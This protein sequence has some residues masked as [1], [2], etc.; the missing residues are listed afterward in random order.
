M[1][2]WIV[3]FALM[4]L[5]IWL[6]S[7]GSTQTRRAT[8]VRALEMIATVLQSP[9]CLNSHQR[10]Q[11]LQGENGHP[12]SPPV[13]RGLDGRGAPDMRCSACHGE[14]T[15]G[16]SQIPGAKGWKMPPRSMTWAGLS[17]AAL[18]RRLKD[19]RMN[20]GRSLKGLLKHAEED[21]LINWAWEQA[22]I[23]NRLECPSTSSWSS[24]PNG[25][26]AVDTVPTETATGPCDRV[27][28]DW[29]AAKGRETLSRASSAVASRPSRRSAT[30][31]W[32]AAWLR[33]G[34]ASSAA[35][36]LLPVGPSL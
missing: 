1:R 20:G 10:E 4:A 9:R 32:V 28:R 6:V 34:G 36:R 35:M 22:A 8:S 26:G 21:S 2:G 3:V 14:A 30:I 12:H 7:P 33:P 19:R 17:V 23:E 18:C 25:C 5:L 29:G 24:L 16:E 27:E 15:N 11:P 31:R 13:V